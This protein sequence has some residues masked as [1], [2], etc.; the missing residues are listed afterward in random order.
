MGLRFHKS[1]NLG[2]GF[3]VNLSTKGIGYS[4]GVKGYRITKTADGRTRKTLSLPGTGISYVEEHKNR[5]VISQLEIEASPYRS[6]G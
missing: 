2:G 5:R 6:N 1:I 3:R 4:W